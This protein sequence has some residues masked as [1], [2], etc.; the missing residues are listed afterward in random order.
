MAEL[1]LN[2]A[3]SSKLETV[4]DDRRQTVRQ[5][6]RRQTDRRAIA[7]SERERN[8]TFA[9]MHLSSKINDDDDE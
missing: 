3:K 1:F 8:F 7:Y 5:T 2:A 9:K 6:D 4:V